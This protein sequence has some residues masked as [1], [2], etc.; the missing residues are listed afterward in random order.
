MT[1]SCPGS[2]AKSVAMEILPRSPAKTVAM[3]ILPRSPAKTVTVTSYGTATCGK[4][5]PPIN[6]NKTAMLC[7]LGS[8]KTWVVPKAINGMR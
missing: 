2:P 6:W 3:E 7:F 1:S 8:P 4:A 5:P